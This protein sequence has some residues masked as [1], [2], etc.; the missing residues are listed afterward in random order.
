MY[1]SWTVVG[2]GW[3]YAGSWEGGGYLKL[4]KQILNGYK[5]EG[6]LTII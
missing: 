1:K 6:F 4:G 2:K 5:P 3:N